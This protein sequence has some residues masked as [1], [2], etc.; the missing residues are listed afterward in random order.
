MG[1]RKGRRVD[2]S[3][4][5]GFLSGNDGLMTPDRLRQIF[6]MAIKYILHERNWDYSGEVDFRLF[7]G[8][9]FGSNTH[10]KIMTHAFRSRTA[11]QMRE[12]KSTLNECLK[13]LVHYSAGLSDT[14]CSLRIRKKRISQVTREF[15]K[16]LRSSNALDSNPGQGTTFFAVSVK[17]QFLGKER[18]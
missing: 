5:E 6:G 14:K 18:K 9:S 4:C 1:N 12:K 2:P 10:V 16:R 3:S 17:R 8:K 7:R 11:T 15:R 13:W